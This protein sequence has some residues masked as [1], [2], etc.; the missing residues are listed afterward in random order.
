MKWLKGHYLITIILIPFI[1]TGC[2]KEVKN[3]ERPEKVV[4]KRNVIY[5]QE[6]YS[7]LADLWKEYYNAFPSE[8][9][10][11][12]W[13]YAVRYAGRSDYKSLLEDGV[14]NYPAN[15]TLLYLK[16][17]TKSG[18]KE[19]LESIQ[20]LERAVE[21]DPT[22]L[23]PWFGLVVDYLSNGELE[24]SESALRKLLTEGAIS[25]VVMDYNYNVISLLDENAILFTNGDNDTYPAWIITKILK[26]RP[27]VKVVNRSLLNTEW[28]PLHLVNNEK[29]SGFIEEKSLNRLRK[30]IMEGIKNGN[31]RTHDA[32]PFSDTLISKI[33]D[34]AV[35]ISRPVYLAATLYQTDIIKKYMEMGD[36]FGLVTKVNGGNRDYPKQ[37]KKQ[38]ETWLTKFRTGGLSSWKLKYGKET[39]SGKWLAINYGE[40]IR[41]LVE[42]ITQYSPQNRLPLFNWYIKNIL[43]LLPKEKI[44]E[45]NSAWCGIND[46]KEI[47]DW[48]NNN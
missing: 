30:E 11:A 46:I 32:G 6:T 14:D 20:L 42:P 7:K 10:Y 13:M 8:D 22:F 25:D 12:N 5:D 37:I 23:D 2:Q 35:E 48:C 18:E 45:I 44:V 34:S 31:L 29:I 40:S 9:A 26:Y 16:A 43:N 3:I 28:Y 19:N 1:L 33:I 17:L 4:S 38:V 41:L 21:L 24:R 15:P 27:D 36:S 39:A 47:R